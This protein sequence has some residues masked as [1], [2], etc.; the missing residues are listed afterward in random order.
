MTASLDALVST[1][2]AEVAGAAFR[3]TGGA[4]NGQSFERRIFRALENIHPWQHC[5]GPDHFDMALDLVGKS[6]THYEFDSALLTHDTLYVVEAKK[7]N[8]LTRQHVGIFVY[9]LFDVLLGSREH[10]A[11]IAVKPVMVSAGPLVSPHAWLHAA[12]WGVILVSPQRPTPLEILAALDTLPSSLAVSQLR[13][14]CERLVNY[15]WRPLERLI[16]PSMPGSVTYNVAT[17]L[18][19]EL[20]TTKQLIEEWKRCA[21]RAPV[22]ISRLP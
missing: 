5:I 15:L 21:L 10:Y 8:K 11:G 22:S 19:L 4:A 14:D 18:I 13:E 1:T 7:V 6:G 3:Q 2:L 12:S 16:Y 9:K 20:D 17:D